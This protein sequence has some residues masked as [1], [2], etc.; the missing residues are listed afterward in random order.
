MTTSG[1]TDQIFAALAVLQAAMKPATKDSTNPAFRS[2]YADLAAHWDALR[3]AAAVAGLSVV[4]DVTSTEAGVSV[5]TRIAHKSGQW[6]EMGPLF[7]P[8]AKHDAHGYGSAV[9]YARRYA[10][11]AAVGTVADD[12]DGNAATATAP[13]KP[14]SVSRPVPVVDTTTGEEV[15]TAGAPEGFHYLA[16]YRLSGEWH[17]AHVLRWDAQGGALKV[18]TKKA[19]VGARLGQFCREGV[20]VRVDVAMKK[21]SSGEAY[22]NG[23]ESYAVVSAP[24]RVEPALV[25]M[26]ADSI[27]F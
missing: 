17:E 12:D 10:L 2:K 5:T 11:S 9:S 15:E 13:T 26:D 3:P 1:E 20:P 6:V 23:V 14:V 22:L 7:V 24:P 8:A 21:N 16:D 18:S 4:Q 27:P 25:D 19:S